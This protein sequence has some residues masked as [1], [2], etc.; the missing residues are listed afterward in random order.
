MYSSYYVFLLQFPSTSED[1]KHIADDFRLKYQFWNCVGAIDGKH[2][3]ITKP[4]HSGSTYFNYKGFFSIVLLAIVNA[5]REFIMIDVGI[6]GRISDGGVFFYSKFG[7]LFQQN[8]LNLPSSSTLPNTT[9][10]HPYV[11]IADEAFALNVN[12]MKPYCQQNCSNEQQYFN[13]RLSRARSVVENAF[14]I[15]ASRFGVF[16]KPIHL[17]PRK[18]TIIT[19]ASC[20]LH[21]FLIKET[22]ETYLF[23]NCENVTEPSFLSLRGTLNRNRS[24]NAKSTR[25]NL[26]RYFCNEGRI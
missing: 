18:A 3:A 24:T 1:W 22:A 9:E 11:F 2:I 17:E 19:L 23:S 7:E 13:Y 16:Q 4:K 26:C 14:G 21:N 15:L 8:A 20:Y 6:N 5:N 12:L 10:K 25:D